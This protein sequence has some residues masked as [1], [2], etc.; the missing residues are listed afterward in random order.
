MS[1]FEGVELKSKDGYFYRYLGDSK[2]HRI[3]KWARI[4]PSGKTGSVATKNTTLELNKLAGKKNYTTQER[5]FDNLLLRG[6]RSGNIPART[7]DARDWFRGIAKEQHQVTSASLLSEKTRLVTK[8]L[9]GEFYF[10]MYDPKYAKTLPYYDMFPAI[11]P[12]EQYSDGFLG[13][14]FH[15]L[16]YILRAKLMDSLYTLATDDRYDE[17]TKLAISYKIT[18]G[19]SAHKEVA[20]TIHRYLYEHVKS[21]FINVYSSEWDIALFLPVAQFKKASQQKVWRDS[22][23]KIK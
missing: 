23:A 14:N 13:L 18:K 17:K 15:Y 12:I 5:V 7:Q 8:L 11:I 19:I 9:P 2:G 1:V 6:I 10:F 4:L 22:R 16:P 21:R 20:P 3:N